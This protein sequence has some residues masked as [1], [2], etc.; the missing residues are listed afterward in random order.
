MSH[1][2]SFI[3]AFAAYQIHNNRIKKK[4]EKKMAQADHELQ[5]KLSHSQN[6]NNLVSQA[7]SRKSH[8]FQSQLTASQVM[9][10]LY[11]P[12]VIF[13][14]KILVMSSR[15]PGGIRRFLW[16]HGMCSM[17]GILMGEKYSSQNLPFSAS[18]HTNACLLSLRM[19][20]MSLSS[21]GQR[22]LSGLRMSSFFFFFFF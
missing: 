19:C 12:E 22:K 5:P 9:A 16:A 1:V 18:V 20:C 2:N 15:I 4:V 10:S 21:L 3:V 6:M 11:I 13:S 14:W 17:I 8:D 7:I